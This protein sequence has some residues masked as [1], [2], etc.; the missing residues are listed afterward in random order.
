V[1]L[2][3]LDTVPLALKPRAVLAIG[4]TTPP[5]AAQQIVR[6]ATPDLAVP[7]LAP[8]CQAMG[9]LGAAEAM[10]R[11]TELLG[12]KHSVIRREAM[13]AVGRCASPEVARRL[14]VQMLAD[15]DATVRQAAA[16][17]LGTRMAAEVVPS[18]LPQLDDEYKPAWKAARDALAQAPAGPTRE[19]VIRAAGVLLDNANPRRR[20][21]GSYL[22]GHFRSD[23]RLDRHLQLLSE[24]DPD[25]V[26]QVAESLGLIG[27][28]EARAQIV[29]LA[30]LA[31]TPAAGKKSLAAANALVAG[32]RLGAS[33]LIP[34]SQR[35][36]NSDPLHSFAPARAAAA[37]VIGLTADPN[38]PAV[39]VMYGPLGQIMEALSVK[40]EIVKALGNLRSR[41]AIGRIETFPLSENHQMQWIIQWST[42]RITGQPEQH[43]RTPYSWMA[44]T[45]IKDT[46]ELDQ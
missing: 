2:G 33:E 45:T 3:R 11:L 4:R 13:L 44:D 27:R 23:H 36:L 7:Q 16:T 40:F 20:E 26:A 41:K 1:L 25:L 18:L 46:T 6:Y 12:H 37:F 8:A 17:V 21:D 14:G 35:I 38:S 34:T 39:E 42:A 10:P 29:V 15:R 31:D 5:G 30:K 32:G 43:P 22:L 19:T 24:E 9:M 28:Q